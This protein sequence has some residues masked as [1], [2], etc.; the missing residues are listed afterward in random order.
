MTGRIERALP[1]GFYRGHFIFSKPPD[2]EMS[3]VSQTTDFDQVAMDLPGISV[4]VAKSIGCQPSTSP[5]N[6]D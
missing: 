2:V 5:L 6:M 3:F 4:K 1:A